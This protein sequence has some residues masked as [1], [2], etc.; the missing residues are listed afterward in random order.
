MKGDA[1][2]V[3]P[4]QFITSFCVTSLMGHF[5]GSQ[6]NASLPHGY[7]ETIKLKASLPHDFIKEIQLESV[8]PHTLY[9]KYEVNE[10]C[11]VEYAS[12]NLVQ[13]L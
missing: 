1:I 10:I 6:L 11:N 9:R 3:R 12:T 7:I 5:G 13:Y 4:Q 8:I 2:H